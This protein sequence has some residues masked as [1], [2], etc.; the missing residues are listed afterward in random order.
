DGAHGVVDHRG[1]VFAGDGDE[2]HE[3]LLVADGAIVPRPLAV[4]PLLTI[5]ALAER[6]AALLADERGWSIG[7]GPTPR[8]ADVPGAEGPDGSSLGGGQPGVRF[9]E[10]MAGWAGASD[11]GDPE[12]GAAR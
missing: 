1:R 4:N 10:R 3:G 11:D 8:L 5:S 12:R 6:T 7:D 2:V 9:T